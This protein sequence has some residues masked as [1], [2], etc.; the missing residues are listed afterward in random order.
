MP[1][2]LVPTYCLLERL[3]ATREAATRLGLVTIQEMLAALVW[4]IE[5]LPER[6]RVIEVP[7]FRRLGCGNR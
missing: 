6:T 3:P 7:E 2:A 4:S 5:H 1:L